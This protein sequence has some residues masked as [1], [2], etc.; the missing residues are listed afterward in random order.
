MIMKDVCPYC[1]SDCI[2][3]NVEEQSWLNNDELFIAYECYCC[4]C[5][6]HYY[7]NVKLEVT[8]RL[9]G[10]TREEVEN[11]IMMEEE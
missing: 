3:Y 4:G 1:G 8:S 7:Q 5:Y 10:K 2:D 11:L 9:I 6:K